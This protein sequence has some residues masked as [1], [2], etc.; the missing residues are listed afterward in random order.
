MAGVRIDCFAGSDDPRFAEARTVRTRVFVE[1]QNV[2]LEE[3]WDELDAVATHLV[4]VADGNAAGTLRCYRE[5]DWWRV[6][7]VAVLPEYRGMG[8]AARM[9]EAC[10]GLARECGMKMS[11]LNAQ[12]DKMGLYEKF[13]YARTGGEFM[14]AS[15]PHYRMEL[16]F[17]GRRPR[18]DAD[19]PELIEHF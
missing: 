13:G 3:E 6:G 14:E 19:G 12:S 5:G 18:G 8:L 10:L 15:I 7:R 2:P 1:E 17:S 9:M 4:A 11:C 16:F